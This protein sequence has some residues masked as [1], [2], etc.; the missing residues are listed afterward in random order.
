M[1]R[2]SPGI[3]LILVMLTMVAAGLSIAHHNKPACVPVHC[4][5]RK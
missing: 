1:K 2:I 3:V 5:E 4:P